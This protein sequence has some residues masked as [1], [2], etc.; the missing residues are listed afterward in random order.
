MMMLRVRSTAA[1]LLAAAAVTG[2]SD[3]V[4]SPSGGSGLTGSVTAP[5]PMLPAANAS[6]RFADQ[7][8]T[9]T[10]QNAAVTGAS[11]VYTFEV[12]TDTAFSS[13]V[14]SK[15][16]VAEGGNGQTRVTLDTLSGGRDYY[17]HARAVSGGTTGPFSP[18]Y[19][20][21]V[22]PAVIVNAPTPIS[23]LNGAVTLPRP[24]LRVTNATRTGAGAVTYRF[25]I[26]NS[27]AFTTV[28][29]SA[30][31]VEGINETGFIPTS[32]LPTSTTLYW[33]ATA[34]DVATGV[35]S[36]PSAVQSFTTRP[37]SQ[38][39]RIA[40]QLGVTLWSRA[41]PSGSF[42]HATMGDDPVFGAGWQ[43]QT[44]HY[45]PGNVFFQSPDVE[46]LRYFDLFDRGYDPDSAI[47]WMQANGYPTIAQ[48]YPG[49]E[50]AV[51]GLRYVYI[52]ARNKVVTNA[53]WDV[54]V[55]VE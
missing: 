14:Q 1:A 22:G 13:R 7:P 35:A 39:E 44:L 11:T 42:G 51:L 21:T 46:M 31:V 9:L 48:W 50:K 23:P 33:R 47:A 54:V 16:N 32:D 20:F 45:V 55:R 17:W 10:V 12:A 37:F 49:P 29:A 8:I 30:T 19:K 24:A 27:P 18:M 28:V 3:S 41:E 26:A 53:I 2:C 4:S 38:A 34:I 6:V 5:V 36:T 40:L 15:D 52:A 43:V 25:E